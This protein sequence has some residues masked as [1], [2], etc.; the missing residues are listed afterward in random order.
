MG[1]ATALTIIGNRL[2]LPGR[3]YLARTGYGAQQTD[4]PAPP[5]RRDYLDAPLDTDHD[6]GSD[7]PFGDKAHERSTQLWAATHRTGLAA[8]ATMFALAAIGWSRR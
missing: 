6:A 4:T 8:G 2:A 5:D 3:Q 1:G 7:G